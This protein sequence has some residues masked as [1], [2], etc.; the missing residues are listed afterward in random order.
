VVTQPTALR[1]ADELERWTLGEPAAEEL[2]RL[3]SLNQEL[4]KALERM[5]VTSDWHTDD[6]REAH[7]HAYALMEKATGENK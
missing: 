3:H 5:Y 4:V 2:R 7:A 1:L 6:G